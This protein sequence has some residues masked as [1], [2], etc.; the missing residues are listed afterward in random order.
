MFDPVIAFV[1][2]GCIAAVSIGC[3]KLV[4]WVLDQRDRAADRAARQAAIVAGACAGY[5]NRRPH[6]EVRRG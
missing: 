1:L 4:S 6:G 3:A 5:L 2:L